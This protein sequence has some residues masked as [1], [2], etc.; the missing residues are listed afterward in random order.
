MRVLMA[1]IRIDSLQVPANFFLD[2]LVFMHAGV[3]YD[4]KLQKKVKFYGGNA[5]RMALACE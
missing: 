4:Q 2:R 1:S 5:V 3:P